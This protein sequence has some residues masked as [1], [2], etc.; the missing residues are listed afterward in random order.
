MRRELAAA[1]GAVLLFVAGAAYFYWS[2]AEAARQAAEEAEADRAHRVP[3]R[4]DPR[5]AEPPRTPS[6]ALD[7]MRALYPD[8]P[9][10]RDEPTR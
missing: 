4:P 9:W 10:K 7:L 3:I 2:A 5:Q 1:F 6:A 8:L